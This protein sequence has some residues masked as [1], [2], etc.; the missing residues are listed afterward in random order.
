MHTELTILDLTMRHKRDNTV[1][2]IH[3]A[4]RLTCVEAIFL[5]LAAVATRA[6]FPHT[7]NGTGA[8]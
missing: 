7:K 8:R 6:L 4:R 3:I 5:Y 2:D 1:V